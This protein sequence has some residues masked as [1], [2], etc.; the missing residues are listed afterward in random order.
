MRWRAIVVSW[1]GRGNRMTGDCDATAMLLPCVG[2]LPYRGH[3]RAFAWTCGD[4]RLCVAVR[5]PCAIPMAGTSQRHGLGLKHTPSSALA[6]AYPIS[7]T[8]A[9]IHTRRTRCIH[10]VQCRCSVDRVFP[11]SFSI[12]HQYNGFINTAK[13]RWV[14]STNLIIQHIYECYTALHNSGMFA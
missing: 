4:M 3:C 8:V 7:H 12:S 9:H 11:V 1:Q 14:V 2:A 5:V 10:R 13:L 6:I